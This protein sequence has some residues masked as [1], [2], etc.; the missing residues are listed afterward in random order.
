M[1]ITP[2]ER[3]T[4]SAIIAAAAA[5]PRARRRCGSPPAPSRA[6]CWATASSPRRPRPDGAAQDRPRALGLGDGRARIRSG[7]RIRQWSGMGRLPR[8]G[9]QARL[10]GR[11]HD[12]DRGVGRARGLGEPVYDKLDA[13]LAKAMMSI[14]AVKAVE[15]GD[16]FAGGRGL[17]RG[18][19]PDEMRDEGRPPR[20]PQQQCRRHARRHLDRA[21]H[22]RTFRRQADELDPHSAP[23]ASPPTAATWMSVTKGRH[24]PCVGIRAVPVG[25]AMM[26]IVLAD[27]LLR[28]RALRGE[29][30]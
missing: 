7:R 29:H 19:R 12:R 1:P 15:M 22:R 30:A 21:G 18:K 16:G 9:A 8:R 13:D 5:L 17:W 28:H 20:I 24:D 11:R 2:M 14:N 23:T 27:H 25:E 10:V 3:N 6:R 4:A 26:A